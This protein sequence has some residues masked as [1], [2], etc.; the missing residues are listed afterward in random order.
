LYFKL[1]RFDPSGRSGVIN[2]IADLA[3][4]YGFTA[5]RVMSEMTWDP[6]EV[7]RVE[8]WP[9]Y[10]AKINSLNPGISI[11]VICQYDA[12][13]FARG[14]DGGHSDPPPIVAEGEIINKNSFYIPA[15]GYC[16]ATTRGGAGE[17]AVQHTA[18][19]QLGGRAAGA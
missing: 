13:G 6:G 14:A 8:R 2:N 15:D 3:R 17:G 9:E 18:H 11:R 12:G 19:Q 1:G 10:E 5:M 16:T 4:S 7:P